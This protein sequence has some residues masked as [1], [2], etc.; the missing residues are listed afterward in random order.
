MCAKFWPHLSKIGTERGPNLPT[1]ADIGQ[2]LAEFGRVTI[3]RMLCHV[4]ASVTRA[5]AHAL[6]ATCTHEL[7]SWH[8]ECD[9]LRFGPSFGGPRC[10]RE[11]LGRSAF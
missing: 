10:Q 3:Y 11:F 8:K 9:P 2:M 5:H 7:V 1:R 6:C 4:L